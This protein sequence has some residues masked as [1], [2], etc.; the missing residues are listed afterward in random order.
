MI[1]A[2]YRKYATNGYISDIDSSADL[3]TV[4]VAEY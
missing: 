2:A 3:D 4:T 1:I